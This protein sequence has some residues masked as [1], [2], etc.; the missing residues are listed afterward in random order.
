MED[1]TTH[2]RS[3]FLKEIERI[4]IDKNGKVDITYKITARLENLFS[5]YQKLYNELKKRQNI[6]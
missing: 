6:A 5:K 2:E 1:T 4:V 3:Y